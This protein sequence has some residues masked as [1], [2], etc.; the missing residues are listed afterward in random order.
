MLGYVKR[1]VIRSMASPY[2]LAMLSYCLFLFAW[3]FPP[4]LYTEYL[5]EP[6]L[7]FLN[8]ITL[9]YFS[10]C[11]AAFCLGVRLSRFF[12]SP[13]GTS[14]TTYVTA[15]HPLLYLIGPL[16]LLPASVPCI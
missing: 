15:G 10:A 11:V 2:G 9:A 1:T 7:M 12:R 4:A 8:P 14:A 6:D 13:T 16:F 5:R 3:L